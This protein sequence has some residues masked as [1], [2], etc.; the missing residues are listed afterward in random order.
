MDE[1]NFTISN[2]I[3]R[4]AKEC[5]DAI[6]HLRKYWKEDVDGAI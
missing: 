3:G 1:M 4:A 5:L 6:K 2:L